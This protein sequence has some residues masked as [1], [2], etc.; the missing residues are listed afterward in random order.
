[1]KKKGRSFIDQGQQKFTKI[2]EDISVCGKQ[3]YLEIQILLLYVG[4]GHEKDVYI[5][6]INTEDY[7][8]IFSWGKRK[9]EKSSWSTEKTKHRE[10]LQLFLALSKSGPDERM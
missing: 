10:K 5:Y 1:M 2:G 7:L 3:N 9:T 6:N 4:F 8:Q